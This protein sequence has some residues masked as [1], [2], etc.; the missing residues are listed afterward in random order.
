MSL[1]AFLNLFWAVLSGAS[2]LALF[3]Q[4][5]LICKVVLV[6]AARGKL[7]P[8]KPSAEVVASDGAAKKRRSY[9]YLF[10]PAEWSVPQ[11]WFSHMYAT[12]CGWNALLL[13]LAVTANA[14][15]ESGALSSLPRAASTLLLLAL[16][17]LHVLRR[18]Y[19]TLF[20]HHFN[21]SARMHVVAYLL[22]LGYYI[23]VPLTLARHSSLIINHIWR[24]GAFLLAAI[25][26][27][28]EEFTMWI[29]SKKGLFQEANFFEVA[30]P[31]HW[32]QLTGTC[33]FIWG[34]WHQ[35]RCHQILRNLRQ[36]ARDNVGSSAGPCA[37]YHIPRGDWFE[38]ASCA[39]YLAEIVL[40]VGL[41]VISGGSDHT[42]WLLFLWVVANLCLAGNEAHK[43]YL[44]KFKNYPKT[45][46]AVIP[47]LL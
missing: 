19:E 16:M 29:W 10:R 47:F 23:A 21:S 6:C 34:S 20:V 25:G 45:R 44:N 2:A 40:Y 8:A 39:H 46:S 30:P 32:W 9:A 14:G 4:S 22:G 13:T 26:G 11:S 31:W 36:P 37:P 35:W 15:R 41:L 17:Q 28:Q 38:H 33:I 3:T 5:P 1:E 27:E 7:W 43:W 12:G 42:L 18:F 24:T